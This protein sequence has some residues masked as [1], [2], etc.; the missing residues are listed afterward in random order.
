MLRSA[1]SKVMWLQRARPLALLCVL[2]GMSVAALLLVAAP[3]SADS[4]SN[5]TPITIPASGTGPGA[6]S[7]YPSSVSVSGMNGPITD[8]Q[9]HP[10]PRRT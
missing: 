8:R 4:F 5:P 9:R 1:A 2:L 3:A 10:P 7:P 6:A